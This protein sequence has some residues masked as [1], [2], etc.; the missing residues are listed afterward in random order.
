MRVRPKRELVTPVAE[1][2]EPFGIAHHDVELIAV[3]D[4]IT[5]AVGTDMDGVALD[6]DAA[7]PHPAIVLQRLVVIAGNEDEVGSLAGL[8]QELLQ[9]VVMGLWP[10]N[11][12][13]D[14]PEVDDVAD[15][16]D[17]GRVVATQEIEEGFGLAGL[18]A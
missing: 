13:P 1:K 14:A 16:V 2:G 6:G 5:P 9:H 12:A 17:V 7:E 3:H 10:V 18:G 15:E 4:E 8:A 11:A